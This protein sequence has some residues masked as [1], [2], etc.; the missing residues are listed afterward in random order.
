MRQS[1]EA[2]CGRQQER[3]RQ[4]MET[5]ALYREV[6]RKKQSQGAEDSRQEAGPTAEGQARRSPECPGLSARGVDGF[7]KN[8]FSSKMWQQ[9]DC[10]GST[11]R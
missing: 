11:G 1:V 10:S 2:D 7:V 5:E 4:M 3:T 6:R 8:S 9:P